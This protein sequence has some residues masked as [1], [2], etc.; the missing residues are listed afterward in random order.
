M[1]RIAVEPSDSAI[2][3]ILVHEAQRVSQV[4]A[5]LRYQG[6][7][8]GEVTDLVVGGESVQGDPHVSSLSA[9]EWVIRVQGE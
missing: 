7:L 5:A 1:Q 4:L 6:L 9:A 8:V 3:Q 2:L